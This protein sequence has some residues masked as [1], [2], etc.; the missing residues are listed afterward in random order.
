MTADENFKGV[1]EN[2]LNSTLDGLLVIGG[3]VFAVVV[4]VKFWRTRF[5]KD[6]PAD[7]ESDQ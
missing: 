5:H 2:I 4:A 3:I 7:D 6:S 1:T